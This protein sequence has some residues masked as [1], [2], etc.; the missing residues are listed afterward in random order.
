VA[1]DN[2]QWQFEAANSEERNEWVALIDKEIFKSL[3]TNE[4][5][6]STDRNSNYIALMQSIRF[7][8]PGND[9]CTDCS[10]PSKHFLYTYN[11][12]N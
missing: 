9:A 4:S 8:V 12:L 10:A 11:Y 6:K 5:S 7:K 2:K 3:Q 1:I